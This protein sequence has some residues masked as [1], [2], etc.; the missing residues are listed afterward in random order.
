MKFYTIDDTLAER[1]KDRRNRVRV[2]VAFD[3]TGTGVEVTIPEFDVVSLTVTS[4]QEK[5]GGTVTRATL[6][7]DN[8]L[9]T[10]CPRLFET[11]RPG[12]NKYNGEKQADGLGYLRPGVQVFVS[13][14]VG[15]DLAFVKRF[16][17][18]VDDNGFQ[19]TATGSKHWITK[20]GLVD[21]SQKLKETDKNRDWTNDEV[22][23]HC[24]I[25]DKGNARFSLVHR[26]AERA[27]LGVA[28]IDCS[29]VTEYLPYVKLSGTVWDELSSL[30]FFY[31]AHIETAPEKPL[32][33]VHSDDAVQF[34]FDNSNVTHIRIYDLLD[35]YRN[36]LRLKWTRYRE[37]TGR[38]LWRYKDAPVIYLADLSATFPF[39][40]DGTKRGIEEDGYTARYT[41]K[42]DEGKTLT[43]VYA[44]NIE[45]QEV[46]ES[47]L[48]T[49]G[50]A[51]QTLLYDVT[52]KRDRA[53]LKLGTIENT[54]LLSASIHGD[55][56]AGEP[57][58]CHYISDSEETAAN[59]TVALNIT[60]PY[61]SESERDGQ[62]YYRWWAE[63]KL[64]K[65]KRKRNGFFLKTNNG[66]FHAR[67]GAPCRIAMRDGLTADRAVIREMELRYR[68]DEAFVASFTLEEDD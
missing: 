39:V 18:Y 40:V 29:T 24:V 2:Q 37:L 14:S 31:D 36:T 56:I 38:E 1:L 34:T 42:T 50:P 17:L 4:L 35:Q 8:T 54:V 11:Y 65:L 48:V 43:V 33:F 15:K 28:D 9:G 16:N 62:P 6:E 30:A 57:N 55:A 63:R 53:M 20:L 47:S 46:F 5:T 7:L 32:V 25:C 23:V 44:E 68:Y 67:V 19:Q 12:Y 60:T 22:L 51:L 61:L 52:G 45:T 27:G 66:V 21:L 64:A 13:Y 41:V 58:F 49:Q 59:G 26:I 3:F 10:Y